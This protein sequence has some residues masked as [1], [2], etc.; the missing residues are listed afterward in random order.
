MRCSEPGHRARGRAQALALQASRGPVAELGSFVIASVASQ[1]QEPRSGFQNVAPDW[2]AGFGGAL[3]PGVIVPL[4]VHLPPRSLLSERARVGHLK[5]TGPHLRH[6][7]KH[8]ND[9]SSVLHQLF[10]MKNLHK[11]EF[12]LLWRTSGQTYCWV[13]G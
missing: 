1:T 7:L 9:N 8:A 11:P 12:T 3:L 2:S 6:K 5:L 4:K 10:T 13:K